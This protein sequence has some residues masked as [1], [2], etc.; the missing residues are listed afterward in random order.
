VGVFNTMS[1]I[2]AVG[3]NGSKHEDNVSVLTFDASRSTSRTR[4]EILT[5]T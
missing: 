2:W 4:S 1:L 5:V 3:N